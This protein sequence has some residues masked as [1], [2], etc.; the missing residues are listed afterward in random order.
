AGAFG[1][2]TAPNWT[3]QRLETARLP[4]DETLRAVHFR[5]CRSARL[6]GC[7]QGRRP[8]ARGRAC[9]ACARPP[10]PL[11]RP[12]GARAARRAA[13]RP[14]APDGRETPALCA[15]DADRAGAGPLLGIRRHRG[16]ARAAAQRDLAARAR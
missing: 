16:A 8:P 9:P 11:R 14:A 12:G 3:R 4:P 13:A 5:P 10:A 1:W 7:A 2:P 15:L 6:L